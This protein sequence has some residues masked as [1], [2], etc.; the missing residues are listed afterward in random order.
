MNVGKHVDITVK[1]TT[2]DVDDFVY[3]ID[4]LESM[5]ISEERLQAILNFLD[6]QVISEPY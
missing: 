3:I 4:D 5:D 2:N 6:T 1:M